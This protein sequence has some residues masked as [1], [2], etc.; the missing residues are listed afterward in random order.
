MSINIADNNT[1][2]IYYN[3]KGEKEPYVR[4]SATK[5]ANGDIGYFRLNE[6]GEKDGTF[7]IYKPNGEIIKNNNVNGSTQVQSE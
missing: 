4:F 2:T 6:F 1:I 5:D 7:I 3:D